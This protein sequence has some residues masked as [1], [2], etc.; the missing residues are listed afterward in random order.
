[1][2]IC[3]EKSCSFDLPCVAFVDF[4][5]LL[6]VCPFP[7]GFERGMW[8]LMLLIFAHCLLFTYTL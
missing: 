6:C 4:N 1:M 3:F 2:T 5:Q 8:D 7:F